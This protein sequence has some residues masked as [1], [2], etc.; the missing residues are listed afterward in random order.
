MSATTL[1]SGYAEAE[2]L[3]SEFIEWL[4]EQDQGATV[5]VVVH[6]SGSGYY[7]QGGNASTEAF[8][9]EHSDYTDHRGNP[10]IKPHCPS[11]NTRTL[12]L[13]VING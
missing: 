8:A 6:K 1:P 7:D 2:M 11:Y 3:V 13:G 10:Y 9:P 12:L 5:E 4:K